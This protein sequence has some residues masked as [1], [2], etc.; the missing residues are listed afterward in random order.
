MARR[1]NSNVVQRVL[2][3]GRSEP[4]TGNILVAMARTGFVDVTV[5]GQRFY[6]NDKQTYNSL[7]RVNIPNIMKA[8][9]NKGRRGII[10]I[11]RKR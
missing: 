9:E 7:S 6:Y 4:K 2:V 11:S 5:N 3:F 10:V 8:Q 1:S